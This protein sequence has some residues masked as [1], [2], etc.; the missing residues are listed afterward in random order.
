MSSQ[1]RK[2]VPILK[3][4]KQPVTALP[5]SSYF[6]NAISFA[7]IRGGHVDVAIMGGLQ[8]DEGANLANWAVPDRPLL[9]MGDAE[10]LPA[11]PKS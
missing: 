1:F 7:M 3:V 2:D 10:D 8:V 5:S 9:G 11:A 4:F 6:D